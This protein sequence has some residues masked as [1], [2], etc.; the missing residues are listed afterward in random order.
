MFDRVLIMSLAQNYLW[1]PKGIFCFRFSYISFLGR[2]HWA[3]ISFQWVTSKKRDF[4]WRSH[5]VMLPGK[6]LKRDG[7]TIHGF[8]VSVSVCKM[9]DNY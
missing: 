7:T 6:S 1:K 2:L 3:E 5:T 8:R 9:Y 4:I